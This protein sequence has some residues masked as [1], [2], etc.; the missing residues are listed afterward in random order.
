M[1]RRFTI[2]NKEILITPIA[3][4]KAQQVSFHGRDVT[5]PNRNALKQFSKHD[6]VGNYADIVLA[7]RKVG[8]TLT[9]IDRQNAGVKGIDPNTHLE[10]RNETI[11]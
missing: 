8:R 5:E 7:S 10:V 9:D 1:T 11:N 3:D 2:F 6:Y 4:V